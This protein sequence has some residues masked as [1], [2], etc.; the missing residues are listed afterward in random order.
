MVHPNVY[1]CRSAAA[2]GSTDYEKEGKKEVKKV[3]SLYLKP[4]WGWGGMLAEFGHYLQKKFCLPFF[5]P[6]L[7]REVG[8]NYSPFSSTSVLFVL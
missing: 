2:I 7:F 6:I 8:R 5:L 1:I 4:R 3:M